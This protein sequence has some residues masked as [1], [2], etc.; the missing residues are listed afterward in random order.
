MNFQNPVALWLLLL[1]PLFLAFFIW[2]SIV[3]SAALRRLGDT[4]LVQALLSQISPFRR[5][6]KA[7]LWMLALA[8]LIF[9]LAQPTLG[10]ESELIRSEGIQ[11]VVA[12]DVSRSMNATDISPSRL[13]RARLDTMDIVRGLEGN[14]IG[15][16]IF[17]REAFQYMPLTFD[18]HAAEVFLGGLTTDMLSL[19]GTNIPAAIQVSMG[20]FEHRSRAQ[21]VIILI[22]DGESFEGD[23]IA[24][25]QIAAE[26][27]VIIYTIG[28]G[29][30]EGSTIPIYDEN[31]TLIDYVTYNDNSLVNS[32]LNADLLQRVAAETGGFYLQ[33]GSDST[34]LVQDILSLQEGALR[35]EIITRPVERFGLFVAI[36]LA[37]LSLEILLPETRREDN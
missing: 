14:D 8:A 27:N 11:I 5:R 10:T 6:M 30:P 20:A 35:D 4:E 28:Y 21:K 23:A 1:I 33:G 13:G 24:A 22:S 7:L 26:E 15:L 3:R 12:I 32:T 34:P 9:A 19:Q 36:A 37:L 31:G 25:A 18:I 29:T 16:V 2:R 17:A